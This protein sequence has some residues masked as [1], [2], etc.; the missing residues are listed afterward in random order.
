MKRRL[1][2]IKLTV[3][4]LLVGVLL[5]GVTMLWQSCSTQ[6]ANWTNIQYHNTT[7]H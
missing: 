3:N 6:K 7:A 5:I 1:N 4:T 2:I